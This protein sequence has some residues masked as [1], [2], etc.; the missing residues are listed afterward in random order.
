MAFNRF[1][2]IMTSEIS[3]LLVRGHSLRLYDRHS[4]ESVV[5]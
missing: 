2:R 4:P 1:I 5:S 3:L